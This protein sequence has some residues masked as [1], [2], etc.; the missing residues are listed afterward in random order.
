M[1]S[2]SA[3]LTWSASSRASRRNRRTSTISSSSRVGGKSRKSAAPCRSA[4]WTQTSRV[5]SHGSA[6]AVTCRPCAVT[7][8]VAQCPASSFPN[9]VASASCSTSTNDRSRSGP[10]RAPSAISAAR[11][12]G[13]E[14][15]GVGS[16][17]AAQCA[18]RPSARAL[19]PTWDKMCRPVQPGSALGADSSSS[20]ACASLARKYRWPSVI[21][22][23]CLD[24]SAATRSVIAGGHRQ[25]HVQPG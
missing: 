3:G 17:V 6:A 12:L 21:Q 11:A 14:Y 2:R 13:P 22:P 1:I 10:Q 23:R 8:S 9:A 24:R 7:T 5:R 18:R 15:I 19:W 16:P 25:V 4:A 20:L